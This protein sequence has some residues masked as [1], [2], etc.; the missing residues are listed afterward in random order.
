MHMTEGIAVE[1]DTQGSIGPLNAHLAASWP[2]GSI[3]VYSM[4]R[5]D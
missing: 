2:K 5:T 1:L 3:H 4:H